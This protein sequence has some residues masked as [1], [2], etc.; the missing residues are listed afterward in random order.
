MIV[1]YI[2]ESFGVAGLT[3]RNEYRCL[4]V[5]YGMLRV[6]DNSEEDYLYSAINPRP[7]DGSSKGGKWEIVEDDEA[8]TL[9]A[10]LERW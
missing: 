6:I 2:G 7:I 9:A 5:E 3:N 10:L 8:G 1:K 4:D